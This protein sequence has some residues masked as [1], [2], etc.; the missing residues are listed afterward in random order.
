MSTTKSVYAYVV[1]KWKQHHSI[2]LDTS[3]GW[4]TCCAKTCGIEH[5]RAKVCTDG[6]IHAYDSRTCCNHCASCV[7]DVDNLFI[8]RETGQ[9]HVCESM[10]TTCS[11]RNGACSI[12]GR[13]VAVHSDTPTQ[14][15]TLPSTNRRGKRRK[16][17]THTNYQ[18]ACIILFDLLFSVRRIKY[19]NVRAT[20]YFDI[21][22]RQTQKL[23]R[24]LLKAGK[25]LV[26]SDLVDIY[27]RNKETLRP[28]R[29]LANY[30]TRDK[31]MDTCKQYAAIVVR[32][33]D[34][35]CT[36]FA[37]RLTFDAMCAALLYH[38]RRGLA[39]DGIYIIPA[40]AFLFSVLPGTFTLHMM[41]YTYA[42][43]FSLCHFQTRM[44]S[45]TLASTDEHS[46]TQK[47]PS[48]R[49]SPTP[50]IDAK[51]P[52]STWQICSASTDSNLNIK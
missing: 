13:P 40:D 31:K 3:G 41:L 42:R 14:C 4:H 10:A 12:S 24:D 6:S 47:T 48:P 11:V 49:C 19:E 35:F 15:A 18:A 32:V 8:C 23:C 43:N 29:H 36:Q 16:C 33:W 37:K 30:L 22:R 34:T 26:T 46:R 52:R 27:M 9:V 7:V 44:P 28:A 45:K 5:V 1:E 50:S 20:A 17:A 39:Y 21:S 51:S 25:P 2:V 38:M